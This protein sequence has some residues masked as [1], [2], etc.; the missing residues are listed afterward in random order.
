MDR[1][2]ID[3]STESLADVIARV[4]AGETV[5]VTRGGAPIARIEPTAGQ[6]QAK[7]PIDF[8]RL[9]RVADSLPFQDES[10]GDFLRR[11]RDEARY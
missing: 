7:K 10:A 6:E 11:L 1:I 5:V 8:E 9:R 3:K 4:E 2:D